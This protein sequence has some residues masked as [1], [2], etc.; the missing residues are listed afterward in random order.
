MD[1]TIHAASRTRGSRSSPCT[2]RTT[3]YDESDVADLDLIE[4]LGKPGEY[5]F[6]RGIHPEMYRSRPWTMRQYAGYATAQETNIRY[7]YLL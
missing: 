6:T 4:R 5:P 3:V 1:R 7:R 2:A